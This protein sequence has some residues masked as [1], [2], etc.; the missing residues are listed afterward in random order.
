MQASAPSTPRAALARGG[1]TWVT[2][3]LLVLVVGGGFL[4]WTWT[5]VWMMHL[6]VKQVVRDYMNRAVKDRND[7]GLLTRMVA[8][9]RRRT[10]QEVPDDD[11]EIVE[12]PAVDL[13]PGAVIWERAAEEDPPT[14]HV[15]FE[16][17]RPV[18]YPLV[19]RWTEITLEVDLTAELT[20]PDW[21]L[22]R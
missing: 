8:E 18:R 2:A 12:A 22:S 17:T 10:E 3:L 15:Q 16:Y 9:L 4:A 14:L 5:P 13:D 19:N 1:I 6:E 20:H 7:A 21:G 11:G